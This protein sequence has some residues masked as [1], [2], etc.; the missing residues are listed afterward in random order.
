M[1]GNC[2]FLSKN[3]SYSNNIFIL[4]F[5]HDNTLLYIY[6]YIYIHFSMQSF[7]KAL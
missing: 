7:W 5:N 4:H 1:F 3:L 6:I 2:I